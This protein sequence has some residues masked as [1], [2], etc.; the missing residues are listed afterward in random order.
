[1]GNDDGVARHG[2]GRRE[3]FGVGDGYALLGPALSI[4]YVC[5]DRYGK[6]K[7]IFDE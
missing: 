4:R 3:A 7:D 1:M 2:G 5:W 6:M